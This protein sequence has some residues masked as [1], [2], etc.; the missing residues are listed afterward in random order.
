MATPMMK[1][2]ASLKS[3]H[4]DEILLFRMGDFYETFYEDAKTVSRVLGL[5]LTSREKDAESGEAIPLAGFPYH[6]LDG[7]L[8]RLVRAGLRVAICEQTEDPSAAKGLVRREVVEVVTAGTLIG[9]SALPERETAMLC[10]LVIEGERAGIAFCDLA[11]GSVTATGVPGPEALEEAGRRLPREM[12]VP[13]D[14]PL[15]A[16]PPECS[17]TRSEP[18]KFDHDL[19]TELIS[20]QFGLRTLEGT[21]LASSRAATRALGGLLSYVRD[22][23]RSSMR[24]LRFDGLYGREEMMLVSRGAA[25][26]LRLVR[27]PPGEEQSAL[28]A[29]IDFSKT[30]AGSRLLAQWLL[31]PPMDAMVIIGRHAA[32]DALVSMAALEE[33][34]KT[35]ARAA[36]LQRQSGKLGARKSGPRDLL[37]IA[38]TARLLPELTDLL[39]GSPSRRLERLS[40]MDRLEDLADRIES[41]VSQSPPLRASDGGAIASGVDESLDELRDVRSGGRS[42]LSEFEARERERTGL[43]KLSVGFNRVFGYYI[44]IPRS[45]LEEVPA[46]YSRKQTLVGAERFVTPELKE[47]ETRILRADEEI[48]R[49]EQSIFSSLVDE[50]AESSGRILETGN[51]LAELDLLSGLA[52]LAIERGYVRPEVLDPAPGDGAELHL[53]AGRHP[54]LDSLLPR[55]E[56]IPNDLDLDAGR[57]ILIVTGPNMAGKSTYLRQAALLL[58]MGQAGSFVPADAMSFSPFD[59]LF[60]RIGSS[61]RITRGQSSFLVEMAEA[62][63]VLNSASN[64]SLAILD[65]LGRG[66]STFDGLSLAWAMIE[67]LHDHPEHRPLTLFATH[68]HELTSLGERLD[69]AANVNVAVRETEDGVVFLYRMVDGGCDRSYGI[70]VASMAGVP[71]AVRTRAKGVLHDLE[72]GRHLKAVH[73]DGSRVDSPDQLALPLFDPA[74]RPAPRLLELLRDADPDSM[75]PRDALERLYELRSLAMEH[76]VEPGGYAPEAEEG[77][78]Q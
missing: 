31:A 77:R 47:M 1:Q 66:T 28:A 25:D 30:P 41:T 56:C 53:R 21:G 24:H 75:S 49:L 60:T 9:S 45:Q 50:L 34:R 63:L 4:A 74:E 61:D 43:S 68:Y 5:T 55:G 71:E 78:R 13:S 42:W 65:E 35:M 62:A 73:L 69:A 11:G 36:D 37:A 14:L 48:L 40:A 7:Y 64:R 27:S 8:T 23:K 33:L 52:A 54:V 67:Y 46:D 2:Y 39:A 18:W 16:P 70:H 6:A 76:E 22:T 17:V 32:V 58:V 38:A 51:A 57:R 26:D 15:D 20:D 59:R 29:C 44:E 12:V 72:A 19:A 3:Q 10:S